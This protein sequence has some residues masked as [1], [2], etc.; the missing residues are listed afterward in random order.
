VHRG[1]NRLFQFAYL[2]GADARAMLGLPGRANFFLLA[3]RPGADARAVG[4]AAAALVPGSE[5]RTSG[6]F[7]QAFGRRIDE[8]FLPV[9]GALVAI[10]AIVGG[11]VIALT[12]YTATVERARDFGVL[13]ALGASGGMLSRIVLE[14][15]VIIGV[16]GSVAGVAAAAVV[17]RLVGRQVPEFVTDLGWQDSV[18]VLLAAVVI[19]GAASTVPL[20]RINHID[21]AMVFRA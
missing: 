11:A 7:A 3:L 17:G 16:L 9:V 20:R 6:E 15:S 21:P 10:G 2:N 5:A 19:A 12:T 14:Q 1:G 13:K 18:A 8:G 4:A